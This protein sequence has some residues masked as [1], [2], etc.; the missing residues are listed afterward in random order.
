MNNGECKTTVSVEI[1]LAEEY[2]EFQIECTATW[3]NDGIGRYEYGSQV[4][5]DKGQ[6]YL[7]QLTDWKVE[8]DTALSD[9]EM[10]ALESYIDTHEQDILET[11]L[12]QHDP[13]ADC[14]Y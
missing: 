10:K 5:F 13:Y 4:C 7:E 12:D 14:P 3:A 1:E 9:E 2:K 8:S 6:D 11:M